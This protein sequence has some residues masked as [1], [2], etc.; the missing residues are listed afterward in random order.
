MSKDQGDQDQNLKVD[1]NRIRQIIS[2]NSFGTAA[3]CTFASKQRRFEARLRERGENS[4]GLWLLPSFINHSC[5]PNSSRLSV[6]S[7]MFIHASKPIERGE[8]ITMSYFD[9]LFPLPQ[10]Q[11]RCKRWGFECKCRRCILEHSIRT[12]L[13]PIITTAGFEQLHDQAEDELMAKR[14][15]QQPSDLDLPACVEFG[16]LSLEAEKIIRRSQLL[17]TEEE[18]NWIRAS[19]IS[20]YM[21]GSHS[22]HFIPIMLNI[23]CLPSGHS[24]GQKVREVIQSTVPGDTRNLILAAG[25]FQEYQ[26]WTKDENETFSTRHSSEQAREACISALGRHSEDVLKELILKYSSYVI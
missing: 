15:S 8:E 19:F 4:T 22:E 12:S 6:G 9:T 17:K 7:A 24:L 23:C 16:R 20:A 1:V 13:E 11:D 10:R 5:L 14:S 21:A 25:Q 3:G 26:R 2:L 18:K